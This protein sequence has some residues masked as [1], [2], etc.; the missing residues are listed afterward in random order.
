MAATTGYWL[1]SK[2]TTPSTAFS[3][4]GF[5]ATRTT[6]TSGGRTYYNY[7]V[8]S[9]TS[10]YSWQNWQSSQP[11]SASITLPQVVA[12]I[13]YQGIYSFSSTTAVTGGTLSA[14][15]LPAT[16][17]GISVSAG[18]GGTA[19]AGS[20]YGYIVSRTSDGSSFSYNDTW[21]MPVT[22]TATPNTNY[23]FDG[24]YLNGVKVSSARTYTASDYTASS[25]S[26][27]AAF[28]QTGANVTV[29]AGTGGT[30]T[31]GGSYSYG[32]TVTLV[33]TP[34]TG[35]TF[36][37]WT[38]NGTTV[39]TSATYSFTLS[40]SN[41]GT[42]TATFAAQQYQITASVSPSGSGTITG[43]GTYSYGD[44]CTLAIV[45]DATQQALT[46]FSRWE[47]NGTQY[48][49]NASI[50]FTV[51][52]AMSFT[53]VCT[54]VVYSYYTFQSSST[55]LGEVSTAGGQY[56]QGASVSCTA[57]VV[58]PFAE[59]VN[60]T[61]SG[62]NVVSTSATYSFTAG[63][64]ENETITAN[65]ARSN[66]TITVSA[67]TGGTV[68]GG[69]TAR[70]GTSLTLTATP[71]TGYEFSH[72]SDGSTENPRV[73][74][75]DGNE[76]YTAVFEQEDS[77]SPIPPAPAN[78][79]D[80]YIIRDMRND[81]SRIYPHSCDMLFLKKAV[82][83]RVQ[84]AA[85]ASAVSSDLSAAANATWHAAVDM[86][87]C[88]A[89]VYAYIAWRTGVTWM[90]AW[91]QPTERG[92]PSVAASGWQSST[93]A[94]PNGVMATINLA[95]PSAAMNPSSP[96]S[97]DF[98]VTRLGVAYDVITDA[99]TIAAAGK[100]IRE[101]HVRGLYYDLQD[102]GTNFVFDMGTT[103]GIYDKPYFT[104]TLHNVTQ[105]WGYNPSGPTDTTT[106]GYTLYPFSPSLNLG[107]MQ[108]S[109][110]D[111]QGRRERW[112]CQDLY[113][114]HT[115][116]S[117]SMD[118]FAIGKVTDVRFLSLFLLA[119]TTGA[120]SGGTAEYQMVPLIWTPSSMSSVV[121]PWVSNP[122][123]FMHSIAAA[124][125]VPTDSKQMAIESP[126]GEAK[127]LQLTHMTT[128]C[129]AHLNLDTNVESYGWTPVYP[130]PSV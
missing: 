5:A 109:H 99:N 71:S 91:A 70:I 89:G 27:T 104:L 123:G 87:A 49:T 83:D 59:F 117:V 120:A 36:T 110:T 16:R 90:T 98:L 6:R 119:F 122:Q 100:P 54:S 25:A 105:R 62:G 10:K 58:A 129:F 130:T 118:S 74:A 77:S 44:T 31:G 92:F 53:A 20:S 56:V 78:P 61:D 63:A 29:A 88:G 26:Y 86:Q 79:D 66:A 112:N 51:T 64:N 55:A 96:S 34:S 125:G 107:Y 73:V 13:D 94:T 30:A 39:S 75:V 81:G 65:F 102:R 50:S 97:S 57:S 111:E 18:T 82:K 95:C 106:S 12:P 28:T 42:Y 84:L 17:V 43:T 22:L 46:P 80:L 108:G 72:W 33:A 35:Y 21:T 38:R 114:T 116:G 85:G 19:S 47:K 37:A 48:S 69:A 4:S 52:G 128:L 7:R 15:I 40:A 103:N 14:Y 68:S 121:P 115:S 1:T 24:W 67:G 60:W 76:T 45:Q 124:Y 41:A 8:N 32:D 126:L 127:Q 113:Y 2:K 23:S 101:D 3:A 93:I 11:S 9:D